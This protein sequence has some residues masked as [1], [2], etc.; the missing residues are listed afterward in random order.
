MVHHDSDGSITNENRKQHLDRATYGDLPTQA[1]VMVHCKIICW[2]LESRGY[3]NQLA[4]AGSQ[5][6]PAGTYRDRLRPGPGLAM[7]AGT[8]RPGA[9]A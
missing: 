3:I 2:D 8:T 9:R 7:R 1:H 5:L 4:R 6:V